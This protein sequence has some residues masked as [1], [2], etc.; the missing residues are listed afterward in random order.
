MDERVLRVDGMACSILLLSLLLLLSASI[1]QS[2]SL[3]SMS[4]AAAV[5]VRS[6]MGMARVGV[7]VGV[8][9]SPAA[10]TQ[11]ATTAVSL[12]PASHGHA[13]GMIDE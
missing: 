7:G 10:R 1:S 11:A 9:W 4:V 13:S 3:L 12:L 6:G 8:V 2:H 5:V